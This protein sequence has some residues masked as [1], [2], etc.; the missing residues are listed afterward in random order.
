MVVGDTFTVTVLDEVL[1]YEVEEIFIVKPNEMEKLAIIPGGDYI[2]L[3]TC[4]PYGINTHRLLLRSHRIDTVY[5]QN[6]KLTSDAV[7]VDPMLVVPVIAAPLI[8]ILLIF[9][10]FGGKLKKKKSIINRNTLYR[11]P[12]Q[13]EEGD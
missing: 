5:G 9:W 6:F 10:I 7:Q 2:T 8:I 3:M 11:L 13:K 12:S 4:T 1:T